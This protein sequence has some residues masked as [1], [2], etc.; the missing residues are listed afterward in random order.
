MIDK[1]RDVAEKL[2]NLGDSAKSEDLLNQLQ[3]LQQEALR[4]LKDKKELFEDG[5]NIIKLGE[6]RF[7]TNTQK[8]DLALVIKD[9]KYFYHLTGTSYYEQ[10]DATNINDLKDVWEQ[11]LP[12]ENKNVNRT[13]YLSWKIFNSLN[14]QK[15]ILIKN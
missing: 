9:K 14:Q 8:L 7:S 12:S 3:V 11:E 1:V 4:A 2:E 10:I 15:N 5:D 13:E 6:Y